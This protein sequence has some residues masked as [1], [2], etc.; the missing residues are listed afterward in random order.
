MDTGSKD[1][2]ITIENMMADPTEFQ[3]HHYDMPSELTRGQLT[4]NVPRSDA[5]RDNYVSMQTASSSVNGSVSQ[6][7]KIYDSAS[8]LGTVRCNLL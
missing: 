7:S 3:H 8:E 1:N 2:V 4:R 6:L 5:T